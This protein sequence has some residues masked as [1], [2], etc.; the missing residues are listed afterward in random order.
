[1][2]QNPRDWT[3]W[4]R[5]L[6]D[7]RHR[8]AQDRAA[9]RLAR[10]QPAEVRTTELPQNPAQIAPISPR[11]AFA[12]HALRDPCPATT[13]SASGSPTSSKLHRPSEQR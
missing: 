13:A 3:E 10:Q 7:Y 11:P 12:N 2:P 4:I 8:R 5:V 9:V 6:L 1:M